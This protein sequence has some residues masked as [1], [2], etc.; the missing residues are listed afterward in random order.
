MDERCHI[1]ISDASP[2]R[3]HMRN[4][5]GG[6]LIITF[7]QVKDVPRRCI[8]VLAILSQTRYTLTVVMNNRN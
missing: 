8:I 2:T 7:S 6:V 1:N 3:F 4:Q 5:P